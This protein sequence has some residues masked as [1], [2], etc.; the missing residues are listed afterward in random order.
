M[1]APLHPSGKA[2]AVA[3]AWDNADGMDV[4]STIQWAIALLTSMTDNSRSGNWRGKSVPGNHGYIL[5]RR[6]EFRL[7]ERFG[8]AWSGASLNS[9]A[10]IVG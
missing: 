3:L 9:L 7:V 5:V 10:A 4:P 8:P 1:R 2:A 6:R